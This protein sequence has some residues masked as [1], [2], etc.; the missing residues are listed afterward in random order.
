MDNSVIIKANKHG[1]MVILDDKPGFDEIKKLVGQKFADSAK[2]LGD[3]KMAVTFEGRELSDDEELELLEVIKSNSDLDV[4]CLFEEDENRS[5]TFEN[6]VN[7]KLMDYSG[8]T[9]RFYKGN[10]RSGQ[11]VEMDNS[12]IV[13]GDVNPGASVTSNGNIIILG[14]LRGTAFAG[15]SGNH[16]AFVMALDMNP[17]QIRIADSIARSPDKPEKVSKEPRIAYL[18]SGRIYIEPITKNI[19]NDIKIN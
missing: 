15:A 12:L 8:S 6:A 5:R 4:V 7:E 19:L 9:A 13:I 17:M 14:S 11:S 2:F 3:C 10:L 16:D 18:E 1:I